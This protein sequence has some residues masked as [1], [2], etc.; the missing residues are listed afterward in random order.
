M[1]KITFSFILL[2]SFGLSAIEPGDMV[3]NFRLL[4]QKGG[5]HE[6]FYYDN[7]KALVFLVQ[8][9]GCPIA[10]HAAPRFQE[11]RDFYSDQE[12]EFFMLNSN[13]QDDRLSIREEA[14]EYGYDLRIL[15]D[16]TQII[17]ESLK[18]SRTGEVFVID[19]KTWTVVYTGALDDRLNY[20]N[21]K[22]EASEH[23]LKNSI[24]EILAGKEVQLPDTD[25]LGCLINFPNKGEKSRQT[26]I[27]YSEDIAPM[28]LE[29]CTVCHRKGGVGPWAMTDYNMVKGFSLMMREVVRTKRM[30][31]WHADPIIGQFSNDRSL[32]NEEIK[33]LV[34]WIEAGAPRGEG[35]D[36]LL[37][38]TTSQSE[39]TNEVKLGPPD[40]I[41][42][43]P[44][45]DIPATGVVDYQYKFV[46]NTVGKD[47]WVKAA[48][49]LPGDKAVL[50]HVITSFGQLETRGP[51]K[52]RL[53]YRDRKGLR[54]YAP[55]I[56]SN[57]Y[58]DE[59]GIFLPADVAFEFQMHY[60]PVGRATVDETRMGIW[61]SEEKPKHEVFSM[62]ILNPSIR[63]PAGAREHKESASK[64]VSKDAL[65]YSVLVH[66]HY[67]GKKM[68]VTAYYPN[69]KTEVLLSVPNYDFNWQTSYDLKEPKFI[70][71][72]TTLVQHQWWDNSAQNKANPDPTVE[73]TWGDQ[74]F[75]EMLFGAYLM[76]VLKE[77]ELPIYKTLVTKN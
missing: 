30:P 33:T 43:I 55:G 56:N 21:Q 60:T 9:N 57:P 64:V 59:G 6:L 46:T 51:R 24:D 20:E 52:G 65:L 39:W 66:A 4:D 38:A 31:P 68:V 72:G 15:I 42:N 19:P 29:N 36:P 71:A 25:S 54:G 69:G 44:S 34:H 32:N 12:V 48:E 11:L 1:K 49:I 61:V 53:K 62:I 26:S 47:V 16:E 74:S 13:L 5:S 77:E 67:R 18:L 7:Q 73:V 27:S 8:G 2:F 28:L 75:E 35:T 23:Y 50:H 17:G 76:R 3:E 40:Y 41:I 70:P 63:I 14:K 37:G 58:P 22:K 10:R 45:T